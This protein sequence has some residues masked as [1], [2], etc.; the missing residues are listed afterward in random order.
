[1]L[2]LSFASGVAALIY[3]VVWFQLLELVVGSTAVSLGVILATFMGGMCIGSLLLP[4]L[5]ST[6]IHPLRVYALLELGIGAFGILALHL[7][8]SVGSVYT[9]WSGYGI[10]GFL[11]RGVV[12]ALC[13]LPPTLLMGATLPAL[14]RLADG[15]EN[16]VSWLGFLYGAN[17]VGAVF[18]CLL[19]GFYLLREYD[20]GAATYVA[21]AINLGTA[22]IALAFAKTAPRRA[23]FDSSRNKRLP[24][25]VMRETQQSTSPSRSRGCARWL[26]R[27]SGRAF[28]AC[29]SALRYTRSPS[30]WRSF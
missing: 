28:L 22:A 27:P 9:A 14:A 12:A 8:P 24:C 13:L 3:E 1:M 6:R 23:H 19:S 26:Q 16:S 15:T 18:G 30:S 11:L 20:V 25:R 17:I 29:S 7:I 21:V 4:R 2:L 5:A 10:S